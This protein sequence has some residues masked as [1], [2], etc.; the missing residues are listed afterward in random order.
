MARLAIMIPSATKT[1][2]LGLL[3]ALCLAPAPPVTAQAS[4]RAY[5]KKYEKIKVSPQQLQRLKRYDYLIEYFSSFSFF[6]PHHKVNPD[7]IR[8]LILAESNGDPMARSRKDARGLTQIIYQTGKQAARELLQKN[9]YFLHVNR[10]Q[11]QHLRP[12]DL[13]IPEINILLA[14][15][16]VSK[17]NYAFQG[18]LD[19]VVSAWNAGENSVVGNRPAHYRETLNHIG[20]VNGYFIYF[21]KQRKGRLRLASRQRRIRIR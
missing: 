18:K 21:L 9:I 11:L 5:V 1:L 4:L 3:L 20:K 10:S 15:Y 6:Q 16:L 19:L 7:F 12:A 13:Y 17:Y 8:A 14:C 2:A